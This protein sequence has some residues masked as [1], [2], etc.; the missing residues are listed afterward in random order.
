[1]AQQCPE[2]H[3]RVLAPVASVCSGCVAAPPPSGGCPVRPRGGCV[4]NGAPPTPSVV[5]FVA[6]LRGGAPAWT[7]VR[8]WARRPLLLVLQAV[9]LLTRPRRGPLAVSSIPYW[10]D[11]IHSG[12]WLPQ[13]SC[14]RAQP[15]L[16]CK[17]GWATQCSP[18]SR[19]HPRWGLYALQAWAVSRTSLREPARLAVFCAA[20]RCSEQTHRPTPCSW[21]SDSPQGR[22][23]QAWEGGAQAPIAV[24]AQHP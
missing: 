23:K 7:P 4:R 11:L 21:D 22:E 16:E 14:P 19:Q 10:Y 15:R 20:G 24:V 13:L 6:S 1:M 9:P 3:C 18:S 8:L 2:K 5:C 12:S 17:Q